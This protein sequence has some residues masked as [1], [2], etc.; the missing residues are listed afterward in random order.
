MYSPLKMKARRGRGR[1]GEWRLSDGPGERWYWNS[2]HSTGSFTRFLPFFRPLSLAS[3]PRFV[4]FLPL[5]APRSQSRRPSCSLPLLPKPR[6]SVAAR[7]SSSL[8]YQAAGCHPG[9]HGHSGA[10][11]LNAFLVLFGQ[12]AAEVTRLALATASTLRT[13]HSRPALSSEFPCNFSRSSCARAFSSAF[14]HEKL[15]L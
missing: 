13:L 15:R 6:H 4:S 11:P 2:V 8:P 1:L 14:S 7:E 10:A 5:N 12:A 3:L 9:S